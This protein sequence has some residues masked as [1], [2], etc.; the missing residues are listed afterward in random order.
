MTQW[1]KIVELESIPKLGA[2]VIRT[3]TMDVAVFRTANDEVEVCRVDPIVTLKTLN[4]LSH[5]RNAEFGEPEE[6]DALLDGKDF[7]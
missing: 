6:Q 4:I 5:I 3:D 2:R 7:H 1:I